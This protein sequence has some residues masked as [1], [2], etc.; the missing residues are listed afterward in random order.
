MP[1]PSTSLFGQQPQQLAVA[2]TDI[3]HLRSGRD[4]LRHEQ[5]VNARPA[6]IAR[7]VRW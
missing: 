3:E 7:G 2:T 4:H 5:K 6:G 1:R